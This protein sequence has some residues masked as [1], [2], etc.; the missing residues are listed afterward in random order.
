MA[1]AGRSQPNSEINLRC[2]VRLDRTT[3]RNETGH[4]RRGRSGLD[5]TDPTLTGRDGAGLVRTGLGGTGQDSRTD[6]NR[7]KMIEDLSRFID[8][9]LGNG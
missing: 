4:D 3:G 1:Q 2:M 5:G 9:G 8:R 7:E 6:L